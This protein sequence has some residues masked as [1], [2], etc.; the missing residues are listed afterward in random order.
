MAEKTVLIIT[1]AFPPSFAPRMGYLAKYLGEHGWKGIA[2]S[3][4]F[5]HEK[6][7]VVNFEFLSGNIPYKMIYTQ[8]RKRNLLFRAISFFIPDMRIAAWDLNK[9]MKYSVENL[10]EKNQID[11]IL[12]SSA[13]SVFPLNIAYNVAK[14]YGISWIADL[15][16]IYE[17]CSGKLSLIRRIHT[18][19]GIQR[20]NSILKSASIITTVSKKHAEVLRNYGLNTCVIYNGADTSIFTPAKYHSL[21]KFIILY[22]GKIRPFQLLSRDV[23]PLFS[24]IQK[25]HANS[26]IDNK[27]F[28]V[29]FYSDTKSQKII[30]D[31]KI[32]FGVSDFIDCFDL[33]SSA[34][35]PK[36]LNDS[37]VLLL[38]L[39]R[40]NKGIMTTKFFEYLA[41]GRP[42]LC[43]WSDE[44]EVEEIINNSRAG[45]AAK[46]EDDVKCF[47]MA[48]YNEWLETGYTKEHDIEAN[49]TK[50]FSRKYNAKQFVELF[51]NALNAK[52]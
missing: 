34:E 14:K 48:K 32:S 6:N 37:S 23:S 1:D 15:R 52:N 11:M 29:Q 25:L 36:I 5:D 18:K 13:Y 28:R 7:T 21:D 2:V 49:N 3:P 9:K 10:I 12:C 16:D 8:K 41:V 31:L 35:I 51:E 40:G 30:N 27:R 39:G 24:A 46:T 44:G 4:A 47:I 38:L 33:V 43:I 19:I 20:R 17:Q 26:A 50:E 45:I 22:T 42:I